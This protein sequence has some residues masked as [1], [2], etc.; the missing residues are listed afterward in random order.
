MEH[1][2]ELAKKIAAIFQRSRYESGKSQEYMAMGIGVSKKTIQNW[3]NGTSFPNLLQAEEWFRLLSINP[4]Q[5]YLEIM[6]PNLSRGASISP[7]ENADDVNE[8][9][10]VLL[11]QLPLQSKLIL[12][13]LLSGKHGSSPYGVLQMLAAHL[14]VPLRD[15]VLHA[16]IIVQN[17]EMESKLGE[18]VLPTDVQ[19]DLAY[20]NNCV[21][22]GKTSVEKR[23][24]T[25]YFKN[26]D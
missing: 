10:Q 7:Y 24:S 13:Y 1:R 9:L 15:R 19:P 4:L 6:L 20:L 18:L 25:Y 12:L 22:T 3:E 23:D 26:Q 21:L 16:S 14:Q 2:A 5:F 11:D 8:K 17:Y